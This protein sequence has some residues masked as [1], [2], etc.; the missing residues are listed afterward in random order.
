[1]ATIDVYISAFRGHM[2]IVNRILVPMPGTLDIL[3]GAERAW[4]DLREQRIT[5]KHALNVVYKDN[6]AHEPVAEV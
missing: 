4:M 3:E 1:M 6:D 5:P 2:V